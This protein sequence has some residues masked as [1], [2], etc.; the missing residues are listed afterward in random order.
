ME[1]PRHVVAVS[2][3]VTN[4]DDR[5][6]LVRVARRGWEL[7]G[8]Q[9]EEGE[10]L[11]SALRREIAE[12]AGCTVDVDG[13][14]GLYSRVQEPVMLLAL[15][16][17]THVGGDPRSQDDDVLDAGWFTTE[18]AERLVTSPATAGRIADALSDR[19]GVVVRSYRLRPYEML[20][21]RL[22]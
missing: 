20:A 3:F 14:A 19:P 2:G 11:V 21:E 15:F 10:D 18:E 7:P 5:I 9:V 16:R 13:L 4:A 6:L 8:G 17:C 12:E 22:V 1:P